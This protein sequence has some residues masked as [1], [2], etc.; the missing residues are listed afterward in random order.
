MP[1]LA[2]RVPS[3]R[4]PFVER[5]D[6]LHLSREFH[7][8]L[9]RTTR[10]SEKGL[11]PAGG[12]LLDEMLHVERENRSGVHDLVNYGTKLFARLGTNVLGALWYRQSEWSSRASF[13]SACAGDFP[14]GCQKVGGVERLLDDPIGNAVEVDAAG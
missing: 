11:V 13:P 4:R 14:D 2:R 7:E 1:T 10:V 12:A 9:Q 8:A 6:P 5:L 3:I